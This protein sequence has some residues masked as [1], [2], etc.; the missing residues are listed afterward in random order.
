[1]LRSCSV[2]ETGQEPHFSGDMKRR[3]QTGSHPDGKKIFTVSSA[4]SGA[5]IVGST[6]ICG[7]AAWLAI[8][9]LLYTGVG[10]HD[11]TQKR[12][13]ILRN[14]PV[15]GHFRYFAE[16][17]RDPFRQ[18]FGDGDADKPFTR[19][20]RSGVYAAA[21]GDKQTR[22]FGTQ[23][24]V[25]KPGYMWINHSLSAKPPAVTEPRLK[26]G[27]PQCKQ[28]YAISRFNVS[29]MSYG[30]LSKNAVLALNKGAKLGGFYQSTGEG[31]LSP[32]HF[33][34][35]TDIEAPDF[36]FDQFFIQNKDKIAAEGGDLVWQIGTGY[37]GCR[38]AEGN[39]DPQ[40]F[41]ERAKLPTV[42]MIEVKLS[43]GAKP[44]HG[45][46]LPKEKLTR[47]IAKLRRVPHGQDVHSPPTHKTF[48]TPRGLLQFVQQL[49]E[50]SGGKPVGFKLC[51]GNRYEFLGI[52]KAMLETGIYPDFITVDGGEG[53]TG[54]APRLF[55]DHIGTP[56]DDGL[57]F[58]HNALKGIGLR[59]KIRVIASGKV[60]N[61][62]DILTKLALGADS[63]NAARAMMFAL[64]CI[65]AL[66]CDTNNCPTGVATQKPS[67][68]K[69]LDVNDK[70]V[71]VA[72][73]QKATIRDMLEIIGA[74]GLDS[75]SQI[76]ARMLH[77]R[78]RQGNDRTLDTVY[79]NIPVGSLLNLATVPEDFKKDWEIATADAFVPPGVVPEKRKMVSLT[80]LKNGKPQQEEVEDW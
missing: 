70:F 65:Q 17:L 55:T 49:R 25:Y 22:P 42:K 34:Q 5:A 10:V 32:F 40:L 31:G 8:P 67:L 80:V 16:M 11:I 47:G 4:V 43:Q 73:Y 33:A 57:V 77:I 21:K 30:A 1:M 3:K 12:H 76:R 18:Y 58:V 15:I 52:C 36:D 60:T 51:V 7:H 27:G 53:G 71:R 74:A 45:G 26:V 61:G 19:D 75:P 14:F 23:M 41:A 13:T 79:P 28:P 24:D 64:G 50:L 72:N 37:F 44:G 56:L 54:A 6:L 39:F 66:Q 63:V 9:W 2:K 29:G 20:Q 68:V 78:D 69:G 48:D 35:D 62:F 38:T 59:D 46:I